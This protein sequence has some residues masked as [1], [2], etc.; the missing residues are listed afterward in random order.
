[1]TDAHDLEIVIEMKR[2]AEEVW[3][4][5]Q[6]KF[7]IHSTT[8]QQLLDLSIHS[9]LASLPVTLEMKER[10][11]IARETESM[12]SFLSR[13]DPITVVRKYSIDNARAR[14][15]DV[16]QEKPRYPYIPYD[17]DVVY[18]ENLTFSLPFFG[19]IDTWVQHDDGDG[20]EESC[21]S[22]AQPAPQK[23]HALVRSRVSK[24]DL[25]DI[26]NELTESIR[27]ALRWYLTELTLGDFSPRF[28]AY[29]KDSKPNGSD[30][31]PTM[32]IPK[33][34][35]MCFDMASIHA[36]L[37]MPEV[38]DTLDKLFRRP[39]TTEIAV[40]NTLV[41][42]HLAE[43]HRLDEQEEKH[44]RACYTTRLRQ[45]CQKFYAAMHGVCGYLDRCTPFRVR[46]KMVCRA[47][48]S[49]P[50]A[51]PG[52]LIKD[53]VDRLGILN[54]DSDVRGADMRNAARFAIWRVAQFVLSHSTIANPVTIDALETRLRNDG[55]LLTQINSDM[56][57]TCQQIAMGSG[58]PRLVQDIVVHLHSV[59]LAIKRELAFSEH[60][61]NATV[62]PTPVLS[63]LYPLWHNVVAAAEANRTRVENSCRPLFER[64][65]SL[66]A[67]RQRCT[68]KKQIPVPRVRVIHDSDVN[69]RWSLVFEEA[70]SDVEAQMK[71]M[72]VTWLPENVEKQGRVLHAMSSACVVRHA[73]QAS[74]EVCLG[75][76]IL[77][78]LT[79][80]YACKPVNWW[81]M[82][83]HYNVSEHGYWAVVPSLMQERYRFTQ[84]SSVA[85]PMPAQ[86]PPPPP[87]RI[88]S[89]PSLLPSTFTSH[90]TTSAVPPPL[91]MAFAS[92]I[93][94]DEADVVFDVQDRLPDNQAGIVFDVLDVETDFLFEEQ[95]T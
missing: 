79:G 54:R 66:L 76:E 34:D 3:Q 62:V 12:T 45:E 21:A 69:P 16:N 52:S 42:Q 82:R 28:H 83:E 33:F 75:T 72:E 17:T 59:D 15:L 43:L 13:F 65:L 50:F 29:L 10:I 88:D 85:V 23:A 67:K 4:K 41:S 37:A 1:M 94:V 14:F 63:Q 46:Q 24:D 48:D 91:S 49:R 18:M 84:R 58:F 19:I 44:V 55:S 25:S 8:I 73:T 2:L 80:R 22:S 5:T 39:Q 74:L 60:N 70:K 81:F 27:L 77:G 78:L 64:H 89:P 68:E 86:P 9:P 32:V 51:F 35:S 38:K 56:F 53:A 26:Y 87:P 61:R 31:I 6:D 90:A 40:F 93:P 95:Q 11:A 20:K 30:E 57:K 47:L 36:Q 92:A 7:P 71:K